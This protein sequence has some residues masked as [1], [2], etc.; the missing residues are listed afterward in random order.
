MSKISLISKYD[1]RDYGYRGNATIY[2]LF[3]TVQKCDLGKPGAVA[4]TIFT[5]HNRLVALPGNAG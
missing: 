2:R 4:L 1:D 3:V 5:R